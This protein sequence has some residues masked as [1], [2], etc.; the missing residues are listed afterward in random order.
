MAVEWGKLLVDADNIIDEANL[1]LDTGPTNGFILTADSTKSGGMKWAVAGAGLGDVTKVGTPVNDQ[2]GVW[3]GD[4]TI[5]GVAGLT[6]AAD[7]LTVGTVA[8]A[9]NGNADTVT[10]NANLTG[11]V[12]SAGNAALVADNV[13]DE[14]N[15]KL[16]SA[17][18]DGYLLT[19]NS[20]A[21]GG[22]DWEASNDNIDGGS[23]VTTYTVAQN[24]DGGGA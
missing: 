8:A 9:L 20:A 10:T 3:T 22:M 15:L 24:I 1:K 2:V 12:T 21:G 17:P 23:A 14:A 11:E 6:Y 19:A 13:I 7:V 4:G 16:D 5:E 18:T